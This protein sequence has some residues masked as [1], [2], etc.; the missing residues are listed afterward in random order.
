MS[1][2]V[3]HF[4]DSRG[5]ENLVNEAHYPEE[6]HDYLKAEA[7]FVRAVLLRLPANTALFEIGCMTGRNAQLAAEFGLNYYG[8][9]LVERFVAEAR[10]RLAACPGLRRFSV[11]CVACEDLDTATTPVPR[12]EPAL[13]FFPFNAF[14][15]VER[16]AMA[17]AALHDLG[18][19]VLIG[20]YRTD[21]ASTEVRRCYYAH[22]GYQELRADVSEDRV[23]FRAREGLNSTVYS[24]A[25]VRALA[26]RAGYRKIEATDVGRIGRMYM[27]RPTQ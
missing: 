1:G 17:L 20:T 12:A 5:G 10:R 4:Y 15:N 3:A 22:C 24:D 16:H 6:I 21:P 23:V 7:D 9:D 26:E 18:H 2:R 14:G 25:A 11:V 13:A 27:L 8:I 19:D